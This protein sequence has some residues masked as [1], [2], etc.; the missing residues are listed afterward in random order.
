MANK[1]INALSGATTPLAGTEVL[2]IVQSN[3]TVKVS[4]SD[5]TA[6]RTVSATQFNVNNANLNG[7]TL[8][9]TNANL[10]LTT[11]ANY[12]LLVSGEVYNYSVSLTNKIGLGD[13]GGH[14][15]YLDGSRSDTTNTILINSRD[16]K[17]KVTSNGAVNIS[18]NFIVGTSNKGVNFTAN[19]PSAGMTSQLLNWYE[20]GTWT[21]VNSSGTATFTTNFA[22]Y[23]RIGRVVHVQLFISVNANSDS[24]NLTI[25][26]L[27]FTCATNGWAPSIINTNAVQTS[28][29]RVE[30]ASTT[31]TAYTISAET[32]ISWLA[33]SG[34][35]IVTQITY[36]I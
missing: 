7:S 23:T 25:S 32:P 20:E 2:P 36:S 24:A 17:F 14:V 12:Q 28:L 1:K 13:V 9:S 27:P 16:N 22:R 31:M 33:F 8:S 18:D 4:V 10:N 3:S 26:G 35:Y 19:T 34:K 21:P 15:L 29:M 11:P 6:G 30:S 5:L